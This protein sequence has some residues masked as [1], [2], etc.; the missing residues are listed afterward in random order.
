MPDTSGYVGFD[1]IL[2][3]SGDG[4]QDRIIELNP[5]LTTSYVGLRAATLGNLAHAMLSQALDAPVNVSFTQ[6]SLTF[7]TEGNVQRSTRL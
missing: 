1:I 3:P 7:D 6:H 2:G 5:R 4:R